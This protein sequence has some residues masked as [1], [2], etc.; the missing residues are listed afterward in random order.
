[1]PEE[2]PFLPENDPSAAVLPSMCLRLNEPAALAALAV[3]VW[4]VP[5]FLLLPRTEV[6]LPLPKAARRPCRAAVEGT[7]SEGVHGIAVANADPAG[8]NGWAGPHSEPF[9]LERRPLAHAASVERGV[10]RGVT[11]SF[12]ARTAFDALR[13]AFA[14][15]KRGLMCLGLAVGL[16]GASSAA[17]GVES[18]PASANTHAMPNRA[19][20]PRS[21][22]G[23]SAHLQTCPTCRP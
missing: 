9:K 13:L 23:H 15:A 11:L 14:K 5:A 6:R 10:R 16:R 1:M 19:E 17:A 18:A 22:S 2:E 4:P 12:T 7:P 21:T 3:V 20:A 8:G